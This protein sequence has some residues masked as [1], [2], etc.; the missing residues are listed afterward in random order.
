MASGKKNYFRHYLYII[1][2][3]ID[4][5]CNSYSGFI[6]IGITANPRERIKALQCSNPRG[7]KFQ[8]VY[9]FNYKFQAV[10]FEAGLHS[11]LRHHAAKNEWFYWNAHTEKWVNKIKEANLSCVTGEFL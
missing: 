8:A 2:E 11:L 9:G 10:V 7:L 5:Y 4:S 1:S 3:E 6:K